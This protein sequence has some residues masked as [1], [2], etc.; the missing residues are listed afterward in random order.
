MDPLCPLL[1]ELGLPELVLGLPVLVLGDPLLLVDVDAQPPRKSPM[2]QNP[3][4]NP[5]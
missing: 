1:P 2:A 3:T 4:S 5:R